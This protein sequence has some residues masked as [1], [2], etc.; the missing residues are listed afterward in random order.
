LIASRIIAAYAAAD[1]LRQ[2]DMDDADL[3]ADAPLL[4]YI[5][6]GRFARIQD[7]FSFPFVSG[8]KR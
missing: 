5:N 2:S 4:A 8:F 6:W 3:L 1:S 7:S